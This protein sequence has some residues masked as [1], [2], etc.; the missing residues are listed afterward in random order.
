[1]PKLTKRIVDAIRPSGTDR[2]Y[3]DDELKGFGLRVRASG[4]KYYVAQTRCRGRLRR[5]TLGP[6]GPLTPEIARRRALRFLAEAKAGE[7]PAEERDRQRATLTMKQLGVRFLDEHVASH[8]KPS[9]QYEYRRSVELF[10]IPAVGTRRLTDISRADVSKLHHDLRHIPY[11]ANR[12]LG[13]LSKM[14]NLCEA[15]G[16]RPDGSNPCL[17]VKKYKEHKRERFLSETEIARLDAALTKAA[18]EVLATP[19]AVAAIRMLLLTGA[20]VGEVLSVKWDYLHLADCYIRLPDS[21]TGEKSIYLSPQAIDLFKSIERQDQ[22]SYVFCGARPGTHIVNLQK[23][24]R[25]VRA[26]AALDDVRLHDLRH[27]FAS[28]AAANGV[29]L[30]IIGALLGH[31]QPQTTARYAHL[32]ADPLKK[33]SALVGGLLDKAIAEDS[34]K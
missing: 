17:H 2:F 22:N 7:D 20:R 3:W 14:F 4:R 6:H 15:W 8:C 32:A 29:S 5:F 30:P 10:I 12:T 31:S 33:A 25:R 19:Y 27:S 9:T 21:K 13:I 11:Q 28:I 24:W 16:L 18:N 1:M 26:L 34:A 23:P